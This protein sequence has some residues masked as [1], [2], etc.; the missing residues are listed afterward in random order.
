[1]LQTSGST[2][3]SSN[4]KINSSV[5]PGEFT[6]GG[7]PPAGGGVPID[8]GGMGGGALVSTSSQQ[9][10]SNSQIS[11]AAASASLINQVINLLES[12]INN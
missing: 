9:S 6:G 2:N 7:V 10:N 3:D 11:N 8:I 1:M 12:R 5:I 4:T